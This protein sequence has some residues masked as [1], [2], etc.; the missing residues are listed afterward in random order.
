MMNSQPSEQELRERLL[1]RRASRQQAS[2]VASSPFAGLLAAA[3]VRVHVPSDFAGPDPAAQSALAAVSH[4]LV[5]N[6]QN[7]LALSANLRRQWLERLGTREEM[8]RALES[9]PLESF[10]EQNIF[11]SLLRGRWDYVQFLNREL[12][13]AALQARQ[14]LDGLLPDLPE[15]FELRQRL[16]RAEFLRPFEDLAGTGF[17]GRTQLLQ[18]LDEFVHSTGRNGPLILSGLGGVGKSSVMARFILNQEANSLAFRRF[19]ILYLDFDDSTLQLNRPETLLKKAAQQFA[20]QFVAAAPVAAELLNVLEEQPDDNDG[21]PFDYQQFQQGLE[22]WRSFWPS[23]RE[24]AAQ[25]P[26][27]LVFDTFEEVL[28]RNHLAVTQMLSLL[29]TLQEI[30][31]LFRPVIAGRALDQSLASYASFAYSFTIVGE[32][33]PEESAEFLMAKGVTD[34]ALARAVAAQVGGT[35]LSLKLAAEVIHRGQAEGNQEANASDGIRDL[36]TR[37]FLFFAISET[38]IQGQL[39]QRILKH[40]R[41]LELRRL[42]HPGLVLRRVTPQVIAEVLAGPCRLELQAL[43]AEERL[44]AA[45]RLFDD[46]RQEAFLVESRGINALRHRADIRRVMLELLERDSPQLV[47]QIHESAIT[48]YE[49]HGAT[50][51]ERAEEIYHRLRLNQDKA[52]IAERWQP[53]VGIYLEDAIAELSPAGKVFVASRAGLTL[54]DESIYSQATLEEWELFTAR[55]IEEGLT[56]KQDLKDLEKLLKERPDRSVNSPLFLLQGHLLRLQGAPDEAVRVLE[57]AVTQAL[58]TGQRARVQ[59]LRQELALAQQAS[60]NVREAI[61]TLQV[62]SAMASD[63]GQPREALQLSLLA[64]EYAQSIGVQSLQEATQQELAEKVRALPLAEWASYASLLRKVIAAIGAQHPQLVLDGVKAGLLEWLAASGTE[65]F[66]LQ[67]ITEIVT[68]AMENPKLLGQVVAPFAKLFSMEPPSPS[69]P[70]R[71]A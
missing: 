19:P 60:G 2:T 10:P 31:T 35:P 30:S 22:L 66:S 33:K 56:Q 62:T 12:L 6:G 45:H 27:L 29:N 58:E 13:A 24:H 70:R 44:Q 21:S 47:R 38:V 11:N 49:A 41:N 32:F 64:F 16:S 50:P 14:W 48:F 26:V 4:P 23:L 69:R 71:K 9:A 1:A 63:A 51:E 57:Q 59:A 39:Y 55:R 17:V 7:R 36:Q 5:V 42:A 68:S 18:D 15:E 54:P 61:V 28:V 34:Q 65:N 40:I 37:S 20:L 52:L 53:G 46:L 3:A 8:L 25:R 43:P 67:S